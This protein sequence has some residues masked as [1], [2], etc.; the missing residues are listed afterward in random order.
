MSEGRTVLVVDDDVDLREILRDVLEHAGYS[1]VLA[2][3]GGQAFDLLQGELRPAVVLLDLFMPAMTGMQVHAAMQGDPRLAT[4]P[5]VIITSDPSSAPQ[6]LPVL[7]KPIRIDDLL[8][9]V[10]AQLAPIK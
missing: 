2:K 7:K 9:V 3:D 6:D 1:I 5:V 4:I 10:G 8:R